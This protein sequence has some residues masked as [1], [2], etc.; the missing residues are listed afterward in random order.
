[1]ENGAPISAATIP[2]GVSKPPVDEELDELRLL[3]RRHVGFA[4]IR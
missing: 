3:L 1:M 4:G 2:G